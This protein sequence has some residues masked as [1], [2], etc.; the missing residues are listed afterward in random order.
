MV[1]TKKWDLPGLKVAI[2]NSTSIRQ[3]L[4]KLNLVQAGGNYEQIKKYIRIHDLDIKHFLGKGSNKGKVI[5]RKV[6]IATKDI[7]VENSDFQSFKLKQRL[8][9][10]GIKKPKC[11]MC[12]WARVTEDGR[13]PVE[14]DHINGKH[15]DNRIENLRILCPNCHSMQSTHR[16][17]NKKVNNNN[18]RVA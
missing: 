3:V 17:R 14:L 1:R 12:G 6:L 8:F 11:E 15:R 10:E 16:G 9:K 5:P 7:L 18:A 4:K 2:K 13:I